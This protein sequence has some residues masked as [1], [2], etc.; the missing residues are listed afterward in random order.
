MRVS[1]RIRDPLDSRRRLLESLH[2]TLDLRVLAADILLHVCLSRVSATGPISRT[3]LISMSCGRSW[4]EMNSRVR[5][6][7]HQASGGLGITYDER[8]LW[9]S[10]WVE[11][12]LCFG[13]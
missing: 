12:H 8:G 10:S 2:H 3:G 5:G 13:S 6:F 4:R 9:D 7:R 11:L 1:N